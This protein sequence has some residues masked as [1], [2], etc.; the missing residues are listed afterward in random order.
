MSQTAEQAIIDRV[1]EGGD[2]GGCQCCGK[3]PSV[4]V[5]SIPGVPMSIA[6]GRNCLEA[7][8]VP[9]WVCFAQVG[10]VD[11]EPGMPPDFRYGRE[12]FA[13]WW[14]EVHDLTLA[15]FGVTEEE[16]WEAVNT[17]DET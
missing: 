13:P 15:Y 6:W 10:A 5:A 1:A 16:F 2:S 8:V 7:D 14:L 9:L 12:M 11:D 4:G 3:E 17:R